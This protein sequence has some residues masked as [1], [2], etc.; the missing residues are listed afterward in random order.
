MG[1]FPYFFPW[2][3][4]RRSK[5]ST[6]LLKIITR[7]KLL[8]SNYLGDYSY[9]FQGSVELIC[10]TLADPCSCSRMQF[11]KIIPL[12]NIREFLAITVYIN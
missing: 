7:I 6:S 2:R 10:I 8:F 1:P 3:S 9:I 12:R 11:Q 5:L 4:C